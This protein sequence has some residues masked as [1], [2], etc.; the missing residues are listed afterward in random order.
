VTDYRL[1]F[2]NAEGRIRH[3]VEIQCEDDEAATKLVQ[4]HADGRAME[5]WQGAR[6][7]AKYD[8]PG[9]KT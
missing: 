7:V 2:L 1:Y 5:L 9:P 4:Q 6:C 8:P 3:A